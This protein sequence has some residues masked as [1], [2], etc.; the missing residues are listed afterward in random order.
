[1]CKRVTRCQER[2]GKECYV[3]RWLY[4]V[5]VFRIKLDKLIAT[6]KLVLVVKCSKVGYQVIMFNFASFYL[7]SA[8]QN[9][10]VATV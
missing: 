8:I 10:I 1:M 6:K 5:T 2:I 3:A 4:Y 9:A 7:F